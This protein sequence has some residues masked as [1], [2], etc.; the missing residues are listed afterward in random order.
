M[1]SPMYPR[2][3]DSTHRSCLVFPASSE[4]FA[5]KAAATEADMCLLDLEDAVAPAEK[6]RARGR[7]AEAVRDLNWGPKVVAVRINGWGTEWAQADLGGLFATAG[8]RLDIPGVAAVSGGMFCL[9]YGFSNAAT[10]SW[11]TPST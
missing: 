7:A 9:V 10:H 3:K 5:A 11:H 8:A 6:A 2:T 4:R 1:P